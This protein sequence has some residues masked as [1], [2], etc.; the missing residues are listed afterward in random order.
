MKVL[1][2]TSTPT[3]RAPS[4][5]ATRLL[6][7]QKRVRRHSSFV[8]RDESGYD[9]TDNLEQGVSTRRRAFQKASSSKPGFNTVQIRMYQYRD[10]NTAPQDAEES[11]FPISMF[12]TQDGI[13]AR[14]YF[15][16]VGEQI[17][18]DCG[19]MVFKFPEDMDAPAGGVRVDGEASEAET[20]FQRVLD[21]LR[22]AKQFPGKPDYRVVEVAVGLETPRR[23]VTMW[24]SR[25]GL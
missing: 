17:G 21:I 20:A 25:V 2:T 14:D 16:R 8:S 22:K 18:A 10:S 7:S 24:R 12:L 4:K 6:S 11:V 23:S 5:S 1:G 9:D 15:D 13:S 19:F 3:K